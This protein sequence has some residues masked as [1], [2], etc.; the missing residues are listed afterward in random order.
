MNWLLHFFQIKASYKTS[1]EN[2]TLGCG[3]SL[4][5][6]RSLEGVEADPLDPQPLAAMVEGPLD[7]TPQVA[8][9]DPVEGATSQKCFF[10]AAPQGAH[11]GAL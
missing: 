6:S 7:G 8:F 1:L 3:G 5:A 10:G 4:G 9:L 11:G 2:G